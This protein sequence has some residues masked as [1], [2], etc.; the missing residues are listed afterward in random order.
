MTSSNDGPKVFVLKL[1]FMMIRGL[2]PMESVATFI[3]GR[4]LAIVA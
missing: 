3:F 2:V 1:L 4:S